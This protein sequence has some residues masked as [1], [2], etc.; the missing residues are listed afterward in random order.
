MLF[1]SYPFILAFLPLTLLLFYG[2]RR[3]GF[4]R[5]A[6]ALLT[7]ASLV[8][9]GWWNPV[10]LLLLVPL[11]L[12]NFALARNILHYRLERPAVARFCMVTGVAGNLAVLG[13]FKYANFFVDNLNALLGLNV[14]LARIVLP[15]GISFFIFQKIALLVDAWHGKFNRLN[16]LDYLLFVTLFSQ[17]IAGPIV[18]HSEV[19]PQFHRKKADLGPTWFA[20]GVTIF[21]IGLAKK[22]LLADTAAAFATPQFNAAAAGIK[23][24]FLAG[25]SGALAYTAQLY[26]DFSGYSD[27]AI[28]TALLFGI[29]LPVN[30]A[31]PYKAASIIDFWRMWHITLS[32]FLR[33]YLYIPLGGNRKGPARRHLNLFLTMLLGGFWHGAGWTYVLWGALHG[34]Y[35]AVNHAWRT[36]RGKWTAAPASQL[37]R[38]C[39]QVVTFS[40]V[41]VG[42]VFFRAHDVHSAVQMLKAMTGFNG[43]VLP[44]SLGITAH[45]PALPHGQV[46]TGLAL[47]VSVLLLGIAWLAPN[48]QQLTGY[49]GPDNVADPSPEHFRAVWRL[50][51]AW[52]IAVGCLFATCLMSLAKVSEFLYFQF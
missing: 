3:A 10:Y 7:L 25:W 48:T 6:F 28:G 32:R 14:F 29:R 52:A 21:A 5:G 9:Y 30:F 36:V 33:D 19:M 17:L 41:V 20:L 24:D 51:P 16:L 38:R 35:L 45:P 42:W 31:S 39:C 22:V 4:T 23:L 18:H 46:D 49:R 34:G 43:I 37:E 12:I 27:M 11:M 2:L 15:L 13:Y 40:A 26:F 47:F 44:A 50:S 1:N 8:F